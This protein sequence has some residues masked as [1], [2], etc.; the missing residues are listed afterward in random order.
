M[1][2]FYCFPVFYSKLDALAVEYNHLLVTQLDSQ[3]QH[4]ETLLEKQRD[5]FEAAMEEEAVK[6]E[7]AATAAEKASI[8]AAEAQRRRQKVESKLAEVTGHRDTLLK[9]KEF[10]KQLN[11]T[12]LANQKAFSEKLKAAEQRAAEQA[13]VITE[14]Q[15]QVRDLMVYLEAQ[16]TIAASGGGDLAGGTVLPLPE[17]PQRR[18]RK[19]K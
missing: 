14:L 9:E 4:F 11:E 10:L 2:T 8:D 6:V 16:Q 12:L 7:S 5:E 1:L 18:G 17:A 3:R 15:E 13:G 19:K